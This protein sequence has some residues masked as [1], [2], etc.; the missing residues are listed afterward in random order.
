M[1]VSERHTLSWLLISAAIASLA[2]WRDGIDAIAAAM[3]IYYAPSALFFVVFGGLLFFVYRLSLEVALLRA[4]MTKLAQDVALLEARVE[5]TPQVGG[6]P[7]DQTS[8]LEQQ[9]S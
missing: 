8:A 6:S 5:A 7:G 4:R 1:R 2:I 9:A 3:G